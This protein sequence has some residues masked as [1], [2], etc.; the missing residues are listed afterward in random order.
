[1]YK[2]VKDFASKYNS[3]LKVGDFNKIISFVH[4]DGSYF[5]SPCA[6]A[7][8]IV[9]KKKYE[10]PSWAR[11]S[12]W[13]NDYY[14]VVFTEHLGYFILNKY[15]YT[16]LIISDKGESVSDMVVFS[17]DELESGELL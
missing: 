16:Q 2:K 15:D 13:H 5:N 17:F 9:N 4:R 6:C 7:V 14:V 3:K 10:G 12:E 8:K 11:A 1:M